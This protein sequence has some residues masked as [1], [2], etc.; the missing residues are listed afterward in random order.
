MLVDSRVAQGCV[1][2][3]R[4]SSHCL[5]RVLLSA[6]P[7]VLVA[8]LYPFVLWLASEFNPGDDGT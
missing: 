8:N 3:G 4:S 6:L 7:F 1:A 5:N 2:R